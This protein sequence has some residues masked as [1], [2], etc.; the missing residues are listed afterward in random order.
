MKKDSSEFL[1]DLNQG[2]GKLLLIVGSIGLVGCLGFL[3]VYMQRFAGDPG[4]AT[5]AKTAFQMIGTFG[6][7][8]VVSA[9]MT[10]IGAIMLFL[11]EEIL[12]AILAMIGIALLTIPVWIGGVVSG[13]EQSEL[14]RAAL[15]KFM[16]PGMVLT[17]FGIGA[18]IYEVVGRMRLRI[19][20]GAKG[21]SLKYGQGVKEDADIRNVLMGKCWQLPYCRKFVREKCPIYHARR[22]CWKERVGCMCE[23]SVIQNAMSGGTIPKD[24]VAA[25][26]FIPYNTK[27]PLEVKIQ[28]CR[29][30]VIYNERQK[31]KYKVAM[32]G[33]FL[34]VAGIYFLT[35]EP[36]KAML[37][38]V[39]QGA[40]KFLGTATLKDG[41]AGIVERSDQGAIIMFQEVLTIA[42]M[43]VIL[44]YMLK[45]VEYLV[46]KLKI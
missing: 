42:L 35:R 27:L 6:Q 36:V 45:L 4:S 14:A 15:S 40:D 39:T 13:L 7:A 10:S 19:K 11:D 12:G 46:F 33:V 25:A 5:S 23:E 2:I 44:A 21:D 16:I 37:G 29:Q 32:P 20:H 8:M 24:M 9:I 43:L 31:H 41:A 30:C 34:M 17:L 38:S 18:V 28:R 26:K 3:F 1:Y 22:T